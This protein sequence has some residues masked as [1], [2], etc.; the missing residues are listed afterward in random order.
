RV[1]EVSGGTVE[2]WRIDPAAYGL[3]S[4]DLDGLAG[5]E[6]ADNA[7]R[8]E[9]LLSGDGEAPVRCA[10][11]L[12][13]AAALYVSGNGWSFEEA[14]NRATEALESGAGWRVLEKLRML[15]GEETESAE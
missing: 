10:V 12:N 11:L 2:Q 6:P 4:A 8:I 15:S 13:A 1:W 7:A 14:V 9:R 5:G 3:A